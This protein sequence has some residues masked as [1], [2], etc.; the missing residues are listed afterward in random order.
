MK[1]SSYLFISFM[2]TVVLVLFT[3]CMQTKDTSNTTGT[4]EE[5]ASENNTLFIEPSDNAIE[6]ETYPVGSD[7]ADPGRCREYSFENNVTYEIKK[8]VFIEGV[9]YYQMAGYPIIRVENAGTKAMLLT[10]DPTPCTVWIYKNAETNECFFENELT[11]MQ[12]ADNTI[13][14]SDAYV[15]FDNEVHSQIAHSI[16]DSFDGIVLEDN[17]YYYVF[18]DSDGIP[19]DENYQ[20]PG[21]DRINYTVYID[22]YTGEIFKIDTVDSRDFW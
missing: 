16:A 13:A 1:K 20:G 7:L 9:P 3:S 12:I 6:Q 4:L 11:E 5:T 15:T 14:V 10:Y 8:V 17:V 2:I 22:I 21:G 18:R 19:P